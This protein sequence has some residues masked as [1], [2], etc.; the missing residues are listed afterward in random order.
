[1]DKYPLYSRA[2]EALYLLG[3]NY[4][5]QIAQLRTRPSCKAF[6]T[7]PGCVGETVKGSDISATDQGMRRRRIR[8]SSRGIR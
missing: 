2:D 6:N 1:M 8:R 5:G 4:E 3:Q 7:P